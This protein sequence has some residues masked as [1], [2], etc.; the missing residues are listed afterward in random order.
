[1]GKVGKIATEASVKTLVL[2]HLVPGEY[3]FLPDE[4]WYDAVR[5]HFAGNLVGGHDLLEL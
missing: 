3:P 4:F 2:S 5:P 1:V